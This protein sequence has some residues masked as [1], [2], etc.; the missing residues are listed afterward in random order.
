MG[1]FDLDSWL[2]HVR[3]HGVKLGLDRVRAVLAALGHPQRRYPSILVGGTNGKGSTVAFSAALL[4]AA[5][6]RVGTTVSPHLTDY[7]ERFGV[8]SRV[9]ERAALSATAERVYELLRDRDDLDELTFFELGTAL[10]A[11]TFAEREVDAAVFEVGMGGELDASRACEPAVGVIVTVDLD[12]CAS[13]GDTVQEIARTKARIAPPGGVLVAGEA[14]PDRLPV[15]ADE[16]A[17]AGA[18]LWVLGRDFDYSYDA[19]GFRFDGPGGS[20]AAPSLGLLGQHQGHNAA[21]ALAA[22]QALAALRDTP[23]PA[24]QDAARALAATRFA[25]RL[26]RVTPAAGPPLLLD[27]AHNTAGAEA[28]A[29]YLAAAPRP[30]KRR[31]LLASMADKDRR[32]IYDALLPHVDEVV[33]TRGLTSD[34]F[35]APAALAQELRARGVEAASAVDPEVGLAL[36][37]DGLGPRDEVLVAGSLYLVGDVR[38]LLGLPLAAPGA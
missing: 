30:P 20:V 31:W 9:V 11:L 21:C 6:L 29:R 16:A 3:A 13:L 23:L 4:G 15:L 32:G 35:A 19:A 18:T 22:A 27:G 37:R 25:G 33:C 34:R 7:S 14:R 2:E 26:E 10:A 1:T 38:P 8:A 12:H 5:G 24:P 28:L 17:E 36:A